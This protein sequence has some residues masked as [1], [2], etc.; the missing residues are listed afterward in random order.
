MAKR[1]RC[2]CPGPICGDMDYGQMLQALTSKY[3]SQALSDAHLREI[4]L[5][6]KRLAAEVKLP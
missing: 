5:K 3:R 4:H 6:W 1:E 2:A